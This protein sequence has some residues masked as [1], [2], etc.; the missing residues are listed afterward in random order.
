MG[1][2]EPEYLK[3]K[4]QELRSNL[5]IIGMNLRNKYLWSILREEPGDVSFRDSSVGYVTFGIL[6][7]LAT[8]MYGL[9]IANFWNI[10]AVRMQ[11]IDYKNHRNFFQAVK[12]G[13][14][15]DRHRLFY[16]GLVPQ[17]TGFTILGVFCDLMHAFR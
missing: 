7:M 1:K 6:G 14:L 17:V 16:K 13:I 2:F 11:N 3:A 10:L 4:R 9:G 8:Q 5:T 12:D 15:I